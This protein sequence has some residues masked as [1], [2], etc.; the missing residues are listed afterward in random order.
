M[1]QEAE[2]IQL[3]IVQGPT[4][5]GKSELVVRLAEHFSGEVVNA[6]S[7]QVYRSMDIGTAKPSAEQ[8]RRVPHHLLDIVA[9]DQPFSAADFLPG[10]RRG[11][12]RHCPKRKTG[13]YLW[14][15]GFVYP[16][17]DERL[18]GIASR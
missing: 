11:D 17:F 18:D 13:I 10:S 15:D 6:D 16:G 7:M 1:V 3:V 5:S 8:L 4:A 14:R 9:P 12:C 2:K